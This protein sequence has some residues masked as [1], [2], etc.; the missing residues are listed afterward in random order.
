MAKVENESG[1][2][3]T[4]Q[5]RQREAIVYDLKCD[6]IRI[7]I[8]ISPETTA[9]ET[10]KA[11]VVAKMMPDRPSVSAVGQSRSEALGALEEAWCEK[12]ETGGLPALDWKA[13]RQAL[14]AVRAI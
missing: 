14:V 12:G 6:S 9:N 11:D 4:D 8:S 10:W 3:I 13:I 7:S 2:R 5:F 1:V